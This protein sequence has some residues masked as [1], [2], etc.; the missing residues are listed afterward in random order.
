MVGA[1]PDV[2]QTMVPAMTAV[3]R[4]CSLVELAVGHLGPKDPA[5]FARDQ[6]PVGLRLP[7]RLG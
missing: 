1:M 4:R 3:V 6:L 5:R 7:D 2:V